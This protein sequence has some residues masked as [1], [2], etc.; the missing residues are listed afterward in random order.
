MATPPSHSQAVLPA[1]NLI[2]DKIERMDDRFLLC[3][4]VQ[5]RVC[6]PACGHASRSR[7]SGYERRLQDLPWQGCA[8]E[9]RL[10]MRRFRCRNPACARKVF[11]EPVPEVA[12]SH[13]LRTTRVGEI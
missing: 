4:H 11:A 9:L 6:C 8:V 13:A 5:Q 2:L 3:A 1:E 10:K 7:H 12:R